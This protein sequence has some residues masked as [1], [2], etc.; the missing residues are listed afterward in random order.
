MAKDGLGMAIDSQGFIQGKPRVV[1]MTKGEGIVSS[2]AMEVDDNGTLTQESYIALS[3]LLNSRHRSP[4]LTSSKFKGLNS[5]EKFTIPL[6]VQGGWKNSEHR[7]YNKFLLWNMETR[8]TFAK[9]APGDNNSGFVTDELGR[10]IPVFRYAV[11]PIIQYELDDVLSKTKDLTIPDSFVPTIGDT[12]V[13]PDD[14]TLVFDDTTFDFA[15]DSKVESV[16]TN[17]KPSIDIKSLEKLFT[18]TPQNERNGK[19]PVEIF[20][21]YQ[22]IGVTHLPDGFNPFRKC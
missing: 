14:A 16:G 18:F 20:S 17:D 5:T 7:D 13:T 3:N 6:Y 10:K 15:L 11:N 21:Y 4:A 22:D 12:N 1:I 9:Q 8:V 2:V 19:T